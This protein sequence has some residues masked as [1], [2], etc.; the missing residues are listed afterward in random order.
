MD[1]QLN[2]DGESLQ[3]IPLD[4]P[5][6]IAPSTPLSEVVQLM[7]QSKRGSVVVVVDGKLA[8]IFT[9][10]DALRLMHDAS[11]S[12]WKRPV[13]DFMTASPATMRRHES[14]ADAIA[15]M[16][17]GGY[18]RLVCV[19]ANDKPTGE[20]T[21]AAILHY[22]IEHFPTVVYTLPPDP[23]HKTRDREGA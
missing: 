2:L 23:H 17:Q 11:P 18:R 8:G 20:L 3:T 19:D 9:E 22:L 14:V 15:R 12:V 4:P 6:C 5:Q 13:S 10:R 16:A 1:F 21:V 7:Q